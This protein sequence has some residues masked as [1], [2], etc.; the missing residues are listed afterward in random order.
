M[1]KF[2]GGGLMPKVEKIKAE[3]I[4]DEHGLQWWIDRGV[5]CPDC[6]ETKFLVILAQNRMGLAKCASEFLDAQYTINLICGVV[7]WDAGETMGCG[8]KFRADFI[9]EAILPKKPLYER[10][11]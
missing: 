1:L 9:E 7:G 11:K 3:I 6:G 4:I 5:K 2:G 10:T 8:C